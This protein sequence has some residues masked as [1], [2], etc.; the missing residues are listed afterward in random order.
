M[1]GIGHIA[2]GM[3]VAPHLLQECANRRA[4]IN[5]SL[6]AVSVAWAAD[7]D[8]IG[9]LLGVPYA[10]AWGHRGATHSL[11]FA[12]IIAL[13]VAITFAPLRKKFWR[14]FMSLCFLTVSHP[15]LDMLTDGGLGVALWWPLS[16][17]RYFFDWRPL[18]VSA[19]GPAAFSFSQLHNVQLTE[20]LIFSPFILYAICQWIRLY[21]SGRAKLTT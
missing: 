9:Y 6:L 2:V 5:Y 14:S 1:A 15:L 21:R 20:A 7:L 11:L 18:H 3:T 10:S 17:A 8:A 19:I 4:V 13:V 16:E 12:G